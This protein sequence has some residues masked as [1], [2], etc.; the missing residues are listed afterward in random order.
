[1]GE[2]IDE[3][4]GDGSCSPAPPAAQPPV[5]RGDHR[6]PGADPPAPRAD[7]HRLHLRELPRQPP[8]VLVLARTTIV[9]SNPKARS[10]PPP[11]PPMSPPS[12]PTL[13]ASPRSP[14]SS[15]PTSGPACSAGATPRWATPSPRPRGPTCWWS[16]SPPTRRPTPGCSSSPRPIG[17]DELA[18]VVTVPVMVGAGAG[19]ALA[20][21]AHLR[22]VLVGS[23]PP[24]RRGACTSRRRSLQ[25]LTQVLESWWGPAEGPMR[26]LLG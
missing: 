17:A 3:V 14:P 6:R 11:P 20:V 4:G 16:P 23:G 15:C 18:G 10:A 7:P 9:V 8:G 13:G 25:D 26:R 12:S 1:M 24:C 2:I 22:P 5:R 21:E 19:H